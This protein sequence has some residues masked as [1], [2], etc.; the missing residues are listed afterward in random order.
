MSQRRNICCAV[1]L[2]GEK[3][4]RVKCRHCWYE[5]EILICVNCEEDLGIGDDI[6]CV[7][8][9]DEHYHIHEMC[10]R[11]IVATKVIE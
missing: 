6:L 5:D 10:M 11:D 1:A 7:D 2:A 9:A 8:I 4:E 3:G